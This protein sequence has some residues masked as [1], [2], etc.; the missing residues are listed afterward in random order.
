MSETLGDRL[1]RLREKKEWTQKYAAT[2]F[3]ITSGALS[4][5]ERGERTPDAEMLKRIAEVYD[6][7]IDYLIG[8]RSLREN[9]Q[10]LNESSLDDY[11]EEIIGREA[12]LMLQ[13]MDRLDEH[14]R[15]LLIIFLQGLKARRKHSQ[16]KDTGL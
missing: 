9:K 14:E 7:S 16:S 6:V 2:V 13:S 8:K 1:R 12:V 5:Y 4:N 3:G 15:E 11:I 10:Y